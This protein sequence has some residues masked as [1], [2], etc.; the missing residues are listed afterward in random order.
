MVLGVV[1]ASQTKRFWEKGSGAA[2][3]TQPLY[4][5][6]E[7]PCVKR[8]KKMNK[9]ASWKDERAMLVSRL[10][11]V[12]NEHGMTNIDFSKQIGININQV[13]FCLV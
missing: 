4:E 6:Q 3:E 13:N 10:D 8:L 1:D 11:E 2:H 5:I 9:S 7:E 12:L